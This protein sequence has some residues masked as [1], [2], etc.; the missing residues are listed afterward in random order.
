MLFAGDPARVCVKYDA[1]T[2][3]GIQNAIVKSFTQPEGS[4]FLMFTTVA[5]ALGLDAP[6]VCEVIHCGL[7]DDIEMYI[8]ETGL[9]G[10]DYSPACAK[11]FY[12][13]SDVSHAITCHASSGIKAYSQND[14]ECR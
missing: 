7:P 12:D 1:S 4:L 11:L 2:A 3:P 5:F 14:T 10:R 13:K 6:N 8:Q 9:A